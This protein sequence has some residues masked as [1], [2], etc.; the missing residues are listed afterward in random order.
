MNLASKFHIPTISFH[1]T[2]CFYLMVVEMVSYG[3]IMNTFEELELAYVKE[4]KKARMDKV[5]CVGHVL[6]C[7]KN[8]LDKA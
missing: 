1:G 3:I 4:Y 5:W 7:N 8:D 6:L 2:C